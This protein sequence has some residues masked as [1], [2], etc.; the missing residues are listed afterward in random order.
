MYEL[1]GKK[2]EKNEKESERRKF[3]RSLIEGVL[4]VDWEEQDSDTSNGNEQETTIELLEVRSVFFPFY[5]LSLPS[6]E[7]KLTSLFV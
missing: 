1:L 6:R 5:S 7:A 4:L 2:G 3:A